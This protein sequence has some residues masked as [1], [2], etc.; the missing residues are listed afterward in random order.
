MV[1]GSAPADVRHGRAV[2]GH[3]A[4]RTTE[5]EVAIVAENL[6]GM[7]LSGHGGA[8]SGCGD[9]GGVV[10]EMADAALVDH[11]IGEFI[12]TSAGEVVVPKESELG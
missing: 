10:D 9:N 8:E 3:A 1:L 2:D 11:V 5:G 7:V 12:D 6:V 4:G